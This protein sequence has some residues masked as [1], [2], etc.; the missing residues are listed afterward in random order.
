MGEI[1]R[2]PVEKRQTNGICIPMGI[3]QFADEG[4]GAKTCCMCQSW[5]P[6]WN[7]MGA[8]KWLDKQPPYDREKEEDFKK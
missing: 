6:V 8:R 1:I 3:V 5:K 7:W 4:C 2:F